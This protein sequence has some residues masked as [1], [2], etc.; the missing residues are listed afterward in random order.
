MSSRRG[1]GNNVEGKVYVGGLPEDATSEELDDVFHK[2]R[3]TRKTQCDHWTEHE[4]AVLKRA[5]SYQRAVLAATAMTGAVVVAA[6]TEA[7]VVAAAVTVAVEGTATIQD[8]VRVLARR[9]SVA[10]EEEE[11]VLAR[12][13]VEEWEGSTISRRSCDERMRFQPLAISNLFHPGTEGPSRKKAH[14][15]WSWYVVAPERAVPHRPV[16][17]RVWTENGTLKQ[18]KELLCL[19]LPNGELIRKANFRGNR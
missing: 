18:P 13:P 11:A 15:M 16:A 12:V 8:L 4:F 1:G 9:T 14:V 2:T 17:E 19:L 6:D 5:L 10:E 7:A 3:A